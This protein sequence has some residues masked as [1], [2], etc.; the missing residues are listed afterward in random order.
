[1]KQ[2]E[3]VTFVVRVFVSVALD[4]TGAVGG[5]FTPLDAA[6]PSAFVKAHPI[7]SIDKV[8]KLSQ[9]FFLIH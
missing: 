3:L 1:M 5:V 8:N 4:V 9:L 2:V 7:Q 6:S